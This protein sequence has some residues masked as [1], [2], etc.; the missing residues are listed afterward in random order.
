MLRFS[1]ILNTLAAVALF[2]L[3]PAAP[4][5][6]AEGGASRGLEGTWVVTVHDDNP[7]PGLPATSTALESYAPGGSLVSSSNNPL[8]TRTGQGAWEKDGSDYVAVIIF[9]VVDASGV[10]TG[11]VRVSHRF[12]LD[13]NDAFTGIGHADLRDLDGNTIATISFTSEGERLEP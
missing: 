11:S 3:V 4:V 12:T 2:L 1:V 10:P 9:F 6:A 5:H 13:G 7:A 8:V